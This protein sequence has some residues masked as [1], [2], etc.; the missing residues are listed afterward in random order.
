MARRRRVARQ[1]SRALLV[2]CRPALPPPGPVAVPAGRRSA[3]SR[4]WQAPAGRDRTA[5]SAALRRRA[6]DSHGHGR[7]SLV[8]WIVVRRA[9]LVSETPSVRARLLRRLPTAPTPNS[10]HPPPPRPFLP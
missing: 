2:H 1:K 4:P 3:S 7:Q 9:A 6:R 5:S 10:T 8:L